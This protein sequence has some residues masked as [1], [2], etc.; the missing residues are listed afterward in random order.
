MKQ[1]EN[2]VL[3]AAGQSTRFWPLADKNL[4]KFCGQPL[5]GWQLKKIK[6]FGRKIFIVTNEQNF[7]PIK[8]LI[9]DDGN[10]ISPVVQ[11][12]KGQAAGLL[13][14]K[15]KLKGSTLIMNCN[16]ICETK[17]LDELFDEIKNKKPDVQLVAVKLSKYMSGGYLRINGQKVEEVVEKPGAE[18]KPSDFFKLVVDYIQDI[19]GFMKYLTRTKSSSDDHYERS[20]SEYIKA[21]KTAYFIEYKNKWVT[22]KYPWHVLA[23]SNFI[24]NEIKSYR[25]RN[26]KIDKTAKI[27]G[28]VFLDDEAQVFE[29]SKIVGPCYIGKAAVIGNFALLVESMIGEESVVGGYSEVTR[30]YLGKNVWLHRN[31]VGDSVLEDNILFGAGSVLANFRFDERDISSYVKGI[32]V[33]T[34]L[35]KLGAMIGSNVKV[36][37]NSTLMPGVKIGPNSHVWPQSLVKEDLK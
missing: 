24:L 16:D 32:R 29:Y 37:V 28:N 1:F 21:G 34:G 36:G 18:K 10:I 19:Q 3:L 12:G 25:G 13:S 23:A 4:F 27:V 35:P 31:Y 6:Q 17:L 22:L 7:D 30:S 33:D 15:D 8:S 2:I 5:L 26:V 14:L 9:I 20:L 11:K